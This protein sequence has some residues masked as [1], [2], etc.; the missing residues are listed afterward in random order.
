MGV[1]LADVLIQRAAQADVDDLQS[2]ADAQNRHAAPQRAA[3][4]QRFQLIAVVRRRAAA[5]Q[6]FFR[7]AGR[8]HIAAAGKKHAVHAGE[9]FI[10]QRFAIGKGEQ[11]RRAARALHRVNIIGAQAHLP[12]FII[13]GGGKGDQGHDGFLRKVKFPIHYS[14]MRADLL[15]KRQKIIAAW[16]SGGSFLR[17]CEKVAFSSLFLC[18]Y[19]VKSHVAYSNCQMIMGD[20]HG[21]HRQIA[22]NAAAGYGRAAA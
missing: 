17:N 12:F 10:R 9:H 22:G 1:L 5:G 4:Q 13:P 21:T 19:V 11:H 16:G 20:M 8:I 7:I 3:Q 2:P 14:M 18:L 15:L 6:H